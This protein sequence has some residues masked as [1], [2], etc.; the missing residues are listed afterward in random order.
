VSPV[1]DS[2]WADRGAV[3]TPTNGFS[4]QRGGTHGP[5][6]LLTQD[7]CNR[8]ESQELKLPVPMGSVEMPEPDPFT[9][10]MAAASLD[11]LMKALSVAVLEAKA[12]VAFPFDSLNPGGDELGVAPLK[13]TVVVPPPLFQ[14]IKNEYLTGFPSV[15]KEEQLFPFLLRLE[16]AVTD[17]DAVT[18]LVG[19]VVQP[20][21]VPL[22]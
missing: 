21:T 15:V 16:V 19:L 10:A 6:P 5:T 11:E 2:G 22:L 9:Q 1:S 13:E 4:P 3:A 18:V 14:L 7:M 12:P 8:A 17:V 20:D